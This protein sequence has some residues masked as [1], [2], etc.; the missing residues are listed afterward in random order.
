MLWGKSLYK[1]ET[2]KTVRTELFLFFIVPQIRQV[3]CIG[4]VV[5][6]TELTLKGGVYSLV[7]NLLEKKDSHS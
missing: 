7:V 2:L 3:Q 1:G 5:R 4:C 6:N